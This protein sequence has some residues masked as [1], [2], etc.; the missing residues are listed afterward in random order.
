[1]VVRIE[2]RVRPE[3]PYARS[4]PRDASERVISG[5]LLVV[6]GELLSS[7]MFCPKLSSPI[8]TR[9]SWKRSC[10]TQVTRMVSCPVL[11]RYGERV[12]GAR[13]EP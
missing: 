11:Y 9:S 10:D 3:H 5:D 6:N 7:L 2:R 8:T 1:L 4:S 12:D 13:E